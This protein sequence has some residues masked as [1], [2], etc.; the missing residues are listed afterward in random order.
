MAS[1]YQ[2]RVKDTSGVELAL[3]DNFTSLSFTHRR[4]DPGT[5]Q[6][7]MTARDPRA[8]LFSTD[9]Q[10]EIWRRDIEN[11]LGWYIE[12]EGFHRTH[13]YQ[14]FE[15][16]REVY[17]S[18]GQGYLDLLNRRHVLYYSGSNYVYK[19]GSGE[20]CMKG[21]VNENAGPGANNANRLRNGVFTGL[22]IEGDGA[23]G[24][25]WY[26]SR[27]YK[28]LLEVC[29]EIA[30]DT[31]L[32]FDI[33]GNGPASFVFQVYPTQRGADRT[34]DGVDYITAVNG[35]GNVPVIFS[36]DRGNM[37]QPSYSVART[38]EAT[39]AVVLGG[40]LEDERESVIALSPQRGASPWNDIELVRQGGQQETD[41]LTSIANETLEKH[42]FEEHFRFEPLASESTLYGRD[43]WFGDLVTV[44]YR[45]VIRN[46]EIVGIDINVSNNAG[47]EKIALTLGD[48]S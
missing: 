31:G 18:Y 17:S 45:D 22:A 42:Q 29:Q 48:V 33:I 13:V 14:V 11:N 19:S 7:Q 10:V 12:K 39:V 21:F 4:N 25:D 2:I 32:A 24:T 47:G 38:A 9:C 5:F 46:K 30:L 8:E 41:E 35:A 27:A 20:T 6:F 44:K 16:G 26:G 40:G 1:I 37:G 36:L 15:N 28:N 23:R 43:Y 3:I 34:A